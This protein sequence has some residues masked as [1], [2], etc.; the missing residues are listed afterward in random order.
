[1]EASGTS[2]MIDARSFR[3]HCGCS[4]LLSCTE[5]PSN[6]LKPR[7]QPCQMLPRKL[8]AYFCRSLLVDSLFQMSVALIAHDI[9]S[10]HIPYQTLDL[11]A[12]H[13]LTS[14]AVSTSCLYALKKVQFH[15][16]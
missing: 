11:G 16:L 13:S 3:C 4:L 10:H 2:R 6:L 9:G 5:S 1:M 7:N 12:N 15:V 8:V 14:S